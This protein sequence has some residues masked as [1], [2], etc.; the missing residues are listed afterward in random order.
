VGRGRPRHR[1]TSEKSIEANEEYKRKMQH[2]STQYNAT[3]GNE[4]REEQ[5]IYIAV[6]QYVWHCCTVPR[7]SALITIEAHTHRLRSVREPP[8]DLACVCSAGNG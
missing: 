5:F 3:Q 6:H 2:A 7:H 8:N 1:R 4:Q